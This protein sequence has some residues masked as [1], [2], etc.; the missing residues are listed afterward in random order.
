MKFVLSLRFSV[1]LIC[2]VA[3]PRASIAQVPLQLAH[4]LPLLATDQLSTP[5]TADLAWKSILTANS[6]AAQPQGKLLIGT[7]DQRQI[8][9]QLA[10]QTLAVADQ[11][12]AFYLANP[13]HSSGPDARDVE[14]LSLISVV[15]DG[16][17]T[18]L[19]RLDQAVADLRT[20]TAVTAKIRARGVAAYEFTNATRLLTTQVA[21]MAAVEKAAQNLITEFPSEPQ[22]YEALLAVAKATEVNK[23]GQIA[24]QILASNAPDEV[25]RSA[26][27]L[28]DRYALIGSNLS[29]VIGDAGS[30]TARGLSKGTPVIVY[31]WATWAPS[32]IELGQMI[33]A[34]RFAAIGICLDAE[35]DQAK[36]REQTAGLGG[37]QIYDPAGEGGA[38]AT[39]L[40]YS[41]AGQIYLVDAKGVIRDVRG[42]D[43]LETKLK[44][45][46]FKTP[47]LGRP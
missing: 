14:I 27:T 46:G 9:S 34:R 26:Q 41:A 42:G 15:A 24:R 40:K 19:P 23:S 13:T 20:A 29:S 32:S 12:R 18:V 11:A 6:A 37:V 45:F 8:A 5:T 4:D 21:R 1:P 17:Q 39:Q 44:T 43:D 38:V 35:I 22:G 36:T 47:I 31:S 10:S 30:G 28:I 33:Q 7:V 25:K 2:L 16:D 3:L